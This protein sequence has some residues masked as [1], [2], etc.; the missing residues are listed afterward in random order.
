MYIQDLVS[1]EQPKSDRMAA[2]L[3]Q[4]QIDSLRNL[5]EAAEQQLGVRWRNAEL[6]CDLV[7][8]GRCASIVTSE[9]ELAEK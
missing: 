7:R 4:D 3:T 1:V 2:M 9:Q 8:E 6:R 5:L